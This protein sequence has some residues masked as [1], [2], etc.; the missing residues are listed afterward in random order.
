M[1]VNERLHAAGLLAAFDAALA[2]RDAVRLTELLKAVY[3]ADSDIAAIL[4]RMLSPEWAVIAETARQFPSQEW[5]AA[6]DLLAQL[7]LP[8][9]DGANRSLDRARV[10]LAILI[11]SAGDLARLRHWTQQAMT[12]W[13]DVLVAAGLANA[14]WQQVLAAA[15]YAVPRND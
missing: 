8:L 3:L 10:K 1:T 13:R 5:Q 7:R 15:G 14:D 2:T 6:T 9:L 4:D 12:D 11:L